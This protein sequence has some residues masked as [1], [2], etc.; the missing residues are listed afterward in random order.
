MLGPRMAARMAM[1]PMTIISSMRLKAWVERVAIERAEALPWKAL[2]VGEKSGRGTGVPGV[3]SIGGG[4][5]ENGSAGSVLF[6]HITGED[7]ELRTV[8]GNGASGDGDA[9]FLECLNDFLVAEGVFPVL[10]LDEFSDLPFDTGVGEGFAV[11]RLVTRSEEVLHFEHA[12]GGGHVFS[13]DGAADGGFVDADGIG[14]LHHGHGA[15]GGGTHLEELALSGDDFVGDIGD[16]LLALVD[17]F[18]EELAAADFVA[19]VVLDLVSAVILRHQ[20]LVGI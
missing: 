16:G 7:V 18:D 2:R 12:V 9:A 13:R 6:A 1:M 8:F 4:V 3:W 10:G 14:D 19:D 11:G 20:V 15:Q 5:R 17:A